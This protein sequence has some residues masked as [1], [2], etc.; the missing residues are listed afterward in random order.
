MNR[1][2]HATVKT[3][4]DR[5]DQFGKCAASRIDVPE[6]EI[7]VELSVTRKQNIARGSV[8]LC[9]RDVPI[10][11]LRVER[12]DRRKGCPCVKVREGLTWVL[13]LN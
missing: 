8:K 5:N 4:V 10:D 9:A 2:L 7:D 13:T 3:W 1:D 12:G 11:S 6:D